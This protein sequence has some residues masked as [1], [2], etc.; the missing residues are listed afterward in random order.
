MRKLEAL[1]LVFVLVSCSTVELQSQEF[2]L[3][4]RGINNAVRKA[5]LLTDVEFIPTNVIDGLF[6]SYKKD[7]KYSGVIYSS[8]KE[9]GSY[10][11][12]NVSIYTFLSA[13]NNPRSV[14]YTERIDEAPY[15]GEACRSYYGT[16]CSAFVSYALGIIPVMTSHDF[17]VSPLFD[18]VDYSFPEDLHVAD[19][20]WQPGHVA[21]IT[22]ISYD[23]NKVSVIEISQAMA[24]GCTRSNYSREQIIQMIGNDVQRVYRYNNICENVET[25]SSSSN[26]NFFDGDGPQSYNFNTFLCANK[27]D[28]YCY[29]EDEDVI[30]NVFSDY[31]AVEIYKDGSLYMTINEPFLEDIRLSGLQYGKYGARLKMKDGSFSNMTQWI[32]VNYSVIVSPS[33]CCI[34]FQSK[35]SK[36][37]SFK[38]CG[39]NGGRKYS[40]DKLYYHLFTDKEIEEEKAYIPSNMIRNDCCYFSITFLTEYGRISLRPIQWNNNS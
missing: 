39:L 32:V 34:S 11:G 23:N 18:S 20:L 2:T 28:K 29:F 17:P 6:V 27:G 37:E 33:D 35:N 30:I 19:V 4:E 40:S 21:L 31:E 8:V 36:P 12:N 24:Q 15:N 5:H 10:V 9:I 13:I 25:S 3:E 38:F 7:V 22:A 26:P 1:F 16:V 14:M